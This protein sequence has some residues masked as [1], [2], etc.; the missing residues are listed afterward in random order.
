MLLA[1]LERIVLFTIGLKRQ[2]KAKK[3]E[4]DNKSKSKNV[5]SNQQTHQIRQK[6]VAVEL[7]ILIEFFEPN[8]YLF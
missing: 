1:K 8:S 3:S 2:I 7:F 5:E 6:N 4:L